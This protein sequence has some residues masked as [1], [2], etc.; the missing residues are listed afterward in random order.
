MIEILHIVI[1]VGT[2]IGNFFLLMELIKVN[3]CLGK[4][5]SNKKEKRIRTN[6]STSSTDLDDPEW[7]DEF[8]DEYMI[9]SERDN[10]Q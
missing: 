9:N 6:S 4:K 3:I 7:V 10:R 2:L 8:I 5:A 1:S